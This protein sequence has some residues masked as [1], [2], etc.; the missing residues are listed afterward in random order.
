MVVLYKTFHKLRTAL[1]ALCLCFFVIASAHAA[2]ALFTIEDVKV[3]VSAENALKAREKAFEEAQVLAFEEL[4][5]RMLSETELQAF[6]PPPVNSISM[7]IQDYEVS[8]EK[9]AS[10]RYSGTYKF[11]F[12]DRAV[13]RFFGG[14]GTQY[15]D[16]AAS[17]PVLIL[18]FLE[19]STGTVLWSHQ[20][21]WMKAWASAPGLVGGL[22]PLILPL[23]DLSDVSDIGDDE[24]LT[25]NK[26][27]LDKM[28]DRYNAGEAVIAIARPEGTGLGI[29]LYRTDRTRPEYVHQILERALPNQTQDQLYARAVQSVK[30]TLRKD[31]KQKTVVDTRQQGTIQ[32]RA[33]FASLQEWSQLQ[34]ALSQVYGITSTELKALSPREAY[35]E[36]T[37]E[38]NLERLSLALQQADLYIEVPRIQPVNTQ[39]GLNADY[40]QGML[41]SYNKQ[42][43]NPV[44]DL[45][46]RKTGVPRRGP[47]A[48][49]GTTYAAPPASPYQQTERERA[50]VPSAPRPYQSSF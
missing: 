4:S 23:G 1:T 46:M 12:Q 11:R 40:S 16:V 26:R 38:G 13:K 7:L 35:I 2:S 22:V 21:L 36:I 18:P 47:G 30:D 48:S 44:Y 31:W 43:A 50:P 10:T 33:K 17:K 32:A 15:T 24:A 39:N 3:D 25:Y 20:N 19:T 41:G 45:R 49:S 6:Q 5:K 37:Y 8:D 28:V 9:L 42:Q 34:K 29:Q 27:N 14:Q